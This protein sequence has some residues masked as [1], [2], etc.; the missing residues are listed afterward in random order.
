MILQWQVYKWLDQEAA[1]KEQKQ[2]CRKHQQ[3]LSENVTY[4]TWADSFPWFNI[5]TVKAKTSRTFLSF[6]DAR[7][8]RL[9]SIAPCRFIA[10]CTSAI[11]FNRLV[12]VNT[13]KDD[14][15]TEHYFLNT[16]MDNNMDADEDYQQTKHVSGHCAVV[17]DHPP[18]LKP[19]A[20]M[21][22]VGCISLF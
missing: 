13:N 3:Y 18:Y 5:I 19:W 22:E 9:S 12:C 16:L 2:W 8:S 1:E 10:L 6:C 20:P 7:W 17:S 15:V 14:A 11:I 21:Y 4:S